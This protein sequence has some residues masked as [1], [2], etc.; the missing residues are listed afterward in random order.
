MLL[1]VVTVP[2]ALS[3]ADRRC[4][5]AAAK[6]LICVNT[7]HY[8][9]RSCA[10]GADEPSA[11][12]CRRGFA[13]SAS[14]GACTAP[15]LATHLLRSVDYQIVETVPASEAARCSSDPLDDARAGRM[16][17]EVL[18][19][20]AATQPTFGHSLG[21][22]WETAPAS[23]R[24][25][26]DGCAFANAS[27][28]RRCIGANVAQQAALIQARAPHAVL[29]AGLM[30]FLAQANLDDPSQFPACCRPG[31]VGQ[32]GGNNT[33]VPD[34]RHPAVQDYYTDWG[35]VYL[36]AG[37]R[38][39]FFGQARLTGG[40]RACA[41]D[42]TGCSRVSAE[43]AAGFAVVLARL[44]AHAAARG[45]GA[46][47]YGPQAASGFQLGN[48][49]ELADWVYGAQHLHARERWLVQPFGVNGSAPPR[50]PQWYG[51]GDWHDA[52]R[53]NNNNRLPVLLDFDN[54]S[55]DEGRPDD[56]RRLSS[57]PNASRAQFVRTLWVTLRLYNPRAT[58]SVP[59]S[60]AAGGDWP[61]FAQ[62]QGQ[63]WSG[64]WGAGDGLY[65][66]AVSCGL[67]NVTAAL[68]AQ[69]AAAMQPSPAAVLSAVDA[70]H[71]GAA[72][73]SPDLTAVWAF[74]SLLGRDFGSTREYKECVSA[75]PPL[76]LGARGARARLA[77]TVLDSAEFR[78][79]ACAA[80][81]GCAEA[82]LAQFMCLGRVDCAAACGTAAAA[83]APN[84]SANASVR[85]A[86]MAD[87]A[88]ALSLFGNAAL[89]D[90]S[91]CLGC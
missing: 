45:Y 65:F 67:L 6:V 91:W 74:R 76:V 39:F 84:A 37:V 41:P 47:W 25:S 66:G 22:T 1:L 44:R 55:G 13:C 86:E 34:V 23:Q 29:S 31:S 16:L 21:N 58:L 2:Q 90:P 68:F 73:T 75:L 88:D 35:R 52:N 26:I 71:F 77:A 83:G 54:F 49:T 85:V 7:T 36:D 81:A 10:T 4:A 17:C 57:W 9:L 72:L 40:G 51:A 18:A 69:P 28:W 87:A 53:V 14:T 63:C 50:G 42:G 33:C 8:T 38:A 46:T 15:A 32:W 79:G 11:V 19:G 61:A 27:G 48:G 80:Q 24:G 43:G 30:E 70:Q 59:L 3:L 12:P 20:T 5:F 82:R 64:R 56:I 60:K 89:M 62:P 78:A